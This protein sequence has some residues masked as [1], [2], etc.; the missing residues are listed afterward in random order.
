MSS[1]MECCF[2]AAE[3]GPQYALSTSPKHLRGHRSTTN[4]SCSSVADM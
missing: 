3:S 2:R 1:L 4:C